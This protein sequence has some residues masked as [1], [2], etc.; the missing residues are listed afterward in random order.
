MPTTVV[1]AF[2]RLLLRSFEDFFFFS[3]SS[4]SSSEEETLR[5]YFTITEFLAISFSSAKIKKV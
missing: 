3:D 1:V 5:F 4:S 2:G